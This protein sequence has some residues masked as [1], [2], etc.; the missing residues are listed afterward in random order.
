MRSL[1]HN[2]ASDLIMLDNKNDKD[3]NWESKELQLGPKEKTVRCLW[4]SLLGKKINIKTCLVEIEKSLNESKEASS[5][6][7]PIYNH[8]LPFLWR[9]KIP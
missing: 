4:R 2:V 3:F 7:N 6:Q 9:T 8:S 5:K 1:R